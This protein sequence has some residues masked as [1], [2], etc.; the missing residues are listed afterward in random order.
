M[1][2]STRF[3]CPAVL[4][5]ICLLSLTTGAQ[6]ELMTPATGAIVAGGGHTV[7]L[8][9]DGTVWAWGTNAH[10]RMGDGTNENDMRPKAPPG[11]ATASKVATPVDRADAIPKPKLFKSTRYP[12]VTPE[13][14]A[15]WDWWNVMGKA[16][17][18]FQWKMP[19][20]FYGKVVDQI[21]A[22][23]ANAQ[24][25]FGWTTAV[26]PK[27]D[28]EAAMVTAEDGTFSITG[29]W[30][31]RLVVNVSKEGFVRTVESVGSYEYAAFQDDLFHVP[32]RSHPVV[33]RLQKLISPEPMLKHDADAR[34]PLGGQIYL[35]IATGKFGAK[36]D[37]EITVRL[38]AD[39]AAAGSGYS[40][41]LR[42]VPGAGFLFTDDELMFSAPEAGYR[43]DATLTRSAAESLTRSTIKARLYVKTAAGKFA[44]V[45]LESLLWER[46]NEATLNA[47]IYFNPSG[48]RNLQF[49]Q[50]KWIN[51]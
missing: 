38:E 7:A 6:A 46:R 28:P 17:P 15:M 39:R 25:H 18:K 48:S 51:R 30:G 12:P 10:G 9:S 16:D 44:A 27:P 14:K 43:D 40:T 1:K 41:V 26:G 45:E 50:H 11:V 42:A 4:S 20:E 22:P 31:K 34:V 32:D 24:V 35:D 36:G 23:V 5:A 29:I 47:L 33:F 21:G 19:I 13:E 2:N 37:I 8:K 3:F 49:D